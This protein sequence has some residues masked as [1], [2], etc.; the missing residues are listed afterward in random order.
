MSMGF[1][2]PQDSP[3]AWR[4]LMIQ[5]AMNQLLFEVSWP[6]LDLLILDLPPGTGDVQLTITQSIE[7]TGA[8]IVSTPQ[9]LALRDAVRGI[10]LF[11]KVN[12]PILGMVQNMS[13]FACTN[14]GHK[15][16]IF[17]LDGARKKCEQI[18][19]T[20]LGDIP[21]HPQICHDADI[22]KPTVV[23]S[24][25]GPQAQAFHAVMEAVVKSIGLR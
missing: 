2:V 5:K 7:L 17:G 16:D 9:D 4:G 14:C 8:V 24:P 1:L 22:G 13:T 12:V 10:D 3:I 15:H 19:V 20:L 23:A 21:L 11:K 6:K 25:E 18:G